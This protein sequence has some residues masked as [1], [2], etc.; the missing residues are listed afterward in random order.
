VGGATTAVVVASAA[1]GVPD[2][3]SRCV[4]V[5]DILWWWA[6]WGCERVGY[7]VWGSVGEFS[8]C[9]CSI[10]LVVHS[11]SVQGEVHGY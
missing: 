8:S 7:E 4:W 2:F 1:A 9:A 11:S 5:C 10:H 3:G 6:G